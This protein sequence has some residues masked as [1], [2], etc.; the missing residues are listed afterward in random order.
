M[1]EHHAIE[2]A[3]FPAR[4]PGFL[5]F[6][7]I[8]GPLIALALP[9][10]DRDRRASSRASRLESA[11]TAPSDTASSALRRGAGPGAHVQYRAAR[12]PPE[13]TRWK[14]GRTIRPVEET[15]RRQEVG[16]S[17]YR[18]TIRD[19]SVR[20]IWS[21]RRGADMRAYSA[22]VSS[23]GS[24]REA[25]AADPIRSTQSAPDEGRTGGEA[26]YPWAQVTEKRVSTAR[27]LGGVGQWRYDGSCPVRLGSPSLRSDQEVDLADRRGNEIGRADFFARLTRA[28]RLRV[29]PRCPT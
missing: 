4:E 15:Y 22:W 18:A 29:R 13:A 19:G 23:E 14:P 7:S 16:S 12:L 11:N 1:A 2:G 20:P 25:E 5:V 9:F 3:V 21:R 8:A 24:E 17:M 10:H 6:Q 27:L 28:P 26:E